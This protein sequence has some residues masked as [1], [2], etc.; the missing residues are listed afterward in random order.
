ME[1]FQ[2]IVKRIRLLNIFITLFLY[3]LVTKK[4]LF[5]DAEGNTP[6]GWPIGVVVSIL[7]S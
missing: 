6:K 3:I 5:I 4:L 7:N 2:P 1:M